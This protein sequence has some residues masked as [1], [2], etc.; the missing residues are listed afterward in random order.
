MEELRVC[1]INRTVLHFRLGVVCRFVWFGRKRI[2][3]NEQKFKTSP[4]FRT[5]EKALPLFWWS[6]QSFFYSPPPRLSRFLEVGCYFFCLYWQWNQSFVWSVSK[7]PQP[8]TW[9]THAHLVGFWLGLLQ[10][11]RPFWQKTLSALP[12]TFPKVYETKWN[13]FLCSPLGFIIY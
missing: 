4:T 5:V 3:I 13:Q 6:Q 9:S 2:K 8:H 1:Q 11:R 10:G 7:Q 12:E